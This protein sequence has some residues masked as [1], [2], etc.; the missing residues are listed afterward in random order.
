MVTVSI[1]L[2]LFLAA[3]E[4]TVVSTAM[5]SIAAQ[6]GGLHIYSW[7]FSIYFLAST[8]MTPIFGRLSDIHGRRPILLAGMVIFLAGSALSGLAQ[9]MPQLIAFRGLQGV[10]G[11]ALL[12]MAFV[13]IGDLYPLERR[14]KMQGLFSGVWALA[15]LAGPLLG[16][17]LVD[18]VSWRWVFFVNLPFGLAAMALVRTH[19]V[20]P[21]NHRRSHELDLRGAFYL[22]A[23][24]GTLIF[25]LTE[26]LN[27]LAAP[28]AWLA[29]GVSLAGY[30]LFLREEL[31]VSEPL[32][33]LRLF[34][35]RLFSV[36]TLHGF[37]AG[38]AMFG[39]TAFI[40]L[41]MQGVIGTSA[42]QAGAALTP[43]IISWTVASTIGSR[44]LLR[45]GLRLVVTTGSLLVFGGA[46]LL[47]ALGPHSGVV[48]PFLAMTLMGLGMGATIPG[49]LIAVQSVVAREEL[50]I[51]TSALQFS[52]MIGGT[53]GVALMGG[54]MAFTL[55]SGLSAGGGGPALAELDVRALIQQGAT[56]APQMRAAL[57]A[58]LDRAFLL[59]V[60]ASLVA[61]IAVRLTPAG[62]IASYQQRGRP[63]P[64]RK[65]PTAS[66]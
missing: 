21:P 48:H 22:I 29:A 24:T 32:L 1:L 25:L 18:F 37:M 6:L 60:V 31:R 16:G 50:G 36:A 13:L 17:F 8:V 19:L 59:P 28:A 11:G 63:T 33:P 7:V 53:L 4:A 2:S 44:L 26:G 61:L 58:A 14:A 55:Q 43:M 39:S 10:G 65:E 42:T 9:S 46:W 41:F 52:R 47:A 66:L 38:L 20:E 57:A 45:L 34:R 5:P 27:L 54:V 15:G 40:P 30:A 23:A 49:F 35:L 64:V 3:V 12:P 62:L 51:A 56:A